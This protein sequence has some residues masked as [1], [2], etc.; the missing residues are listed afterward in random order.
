[1]MRMD[2]KV[3]GKLRKHNRIPGYEGNP[4]IPHILYRDVPVFLVTP[5]EMDAAIRLENLD[6]IREHKDYPLLI[7]TDKKHVLA[8]DPQGYNYARYVCVIDV[9]TARTILSRV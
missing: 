1:M 6:V 4:N 9:D 7:L 3:F 5:Q 8:V 2:V